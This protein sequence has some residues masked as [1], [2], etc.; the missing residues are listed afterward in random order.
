LHFFK[1]EIRGFKSQRKTLLN[2]STIDRGFARK[3]K[4]LFFNTARFTLFGIK[5]TENAFGFCTVRF[6]LP[7]C[8]EKR[9]LL[10]YDMNRAFLYKNGYFPRT[11]L[12]TL[13]VIN[14]K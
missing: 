14:G 1:S 12:I 9:F 7:L 11:I 2:F 13:L 8:N 5:K 6:A 3:R 10:L 4:T